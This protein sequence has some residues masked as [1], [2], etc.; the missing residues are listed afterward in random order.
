MPKPHPILLDFDDCDDNPLDTIH[1]QPEPETMRR[2]GTRD[3]WEADEIERLRVENETLK[4]I[5]QATRDTLGTIDDWLGSASTQ[6]AAKDS[7]WR[8]QRRLQQAGF[9]YSWRNALEW[10]HV[11]LKELNEA[12]FFNSPDFFRYDPTADKEKPYRVYGNAQGVTLKEFVERYE[13]A[14]AEFRRVYAAQPV[15]VQAALEGLKLIL[16]GDEQP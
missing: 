9:E 16:L 14:R 3:G 12:G 7:M 13:I 11:T 10:R 5:C 15:H 6:Q 2:V 4:G 1:Y 8:L